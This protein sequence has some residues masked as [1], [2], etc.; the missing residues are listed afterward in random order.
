MRVEMFKE[1]Q[2]RIQN[3]KKSAKKIRQDSVPAII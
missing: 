3:I 1:A 2:P